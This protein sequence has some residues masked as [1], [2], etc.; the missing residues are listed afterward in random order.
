MNRLAGAISLAALVSV[1]VSCAAPEPPPPPPT[2]VE[3]RDL[4][5]GLTAV[6]EELTVAANQGSSLELSPVNPA[7]GGTIWFAVGP[8]Q[9][10]INL[11]AAVKDHQQQ[12]EGLPD[13][14]YEGAQELQG[15]FG[16]AFYSRGR[17]TERGSPVEETVIFLIH[18]SASR[19]LAIHYRYPARDDSSQ[20]VEQL[21]D[22]LSY[23]E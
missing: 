3:N 17:Y 13:G 10:G 5:I 2:G 20:R 22:V 1:V 15:E 12:I 18:P 21:I 4:G 9:V 16:T 7:L 8:E 14:K 23:L 19:L 6:P 11:V